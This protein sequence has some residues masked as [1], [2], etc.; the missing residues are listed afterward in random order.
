MNA[1]TPSRNIWER[2]RIVI[3][4]GLKLLAIAV[5]CLVVFAL[6]F[7][8]WVKTG[9]IKF[10]I[11]ARWFGLFY[12]TCAL[13][14]VIL[15]QFKGDLRRGRFWGALLACLA[16]HVGA[17]VLVLRSYPQWPQV[18]FMFIFLIEG[19]LVMAALRSV[20]DTRR[21]R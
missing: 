16:L 14:W 2:V 21:H 3:L 9:L 15:R 18:W 13:L 17:F 5:G 7:F 19:T 20:V 11:P 4:E 6:A 8:I 10:H 12:W 1:P